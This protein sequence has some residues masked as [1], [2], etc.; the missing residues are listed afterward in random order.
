MG[1]IAAAHTLRFTVANFVSHFEL[2]FLVLPQ[3]TE[4]QP[5]EA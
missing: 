1:N 4:A 2:A 3:I 5:P